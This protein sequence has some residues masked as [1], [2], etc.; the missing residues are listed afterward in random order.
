MAGIVNTY[1]G[2][3]YSFSSLIGLLLWFFS[4]FLQSCSSISSGKLNV[5]LNRGDLLRE[6]L[7]E[8]R[9]RDIQEGR[10]ITVREEN[11]P[12]LHEIRGKLGR[13]RNEGFLDH[14]NIPANPTRIDRMKKEL[15]FVF[16]NWLRCKQ[17]RDMNVRAKVTHFSRFIDIQGRYYY[18][19]LIDNP[20][21]QEHPDTL[22]KL[23]YNIEHD[24][25]EFKIKDL[26]NDQ[27]ILMA[28][29]DER[30]ELKEEQANNLDNT[31]RGV[32]PHSDFGEG[33]ERVDIDHLIR[34]NHVTIELPYSLHKFKNRFIDSLTNIPKRTVDR[35]SRVY[36]I[37]RFEE[38][39]AG[40]F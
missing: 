8:R 25:A 30:D 24:R 31:E 10:P 9:K 21:V 37:S 15:M 1:R 28:D 12:M 40:I 38:R 11:Q 36:W 35:N 16:C 23:I 13:L 22:W 4:F 3:W 32:A 33:F 34:N 7:L 19:N 5:H 26:Y 18:P 20:G 29:P 17:S 39:N 2:V 6:N 14:Y 27:R